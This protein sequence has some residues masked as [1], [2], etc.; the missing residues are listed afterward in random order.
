[1]GKQNSK[2]SPKNL[3]DLKEKTSFTDQELLEWN[4][5]FLKDYPS[6]NLSLIEFKKIYEKCFPYGDAETFAGHVFRTL[7]TNKDGKIDFREF[8]TALSVTSRGTL[9]AKLK[10]AFSMYDLDC[11]GYISKEEMLEIVRAIYK[12]SGSADEETPAKL[13]SNI[14]LEMDKNIDGKISLSEFVDGSK[15]DPSIVVLLQGG[16]TLDGPT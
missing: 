12:M 8:I 5:G 1:M 4:K 13:V 7:D 16:M 15:R 10:L 3:N 11:N 9:E 2:L 14:F 6:G